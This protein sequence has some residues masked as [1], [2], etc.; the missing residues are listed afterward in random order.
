MR[1]RAAAGVV[2]CTV[3]VTVFVRACVVVFLFLLSSL[4]LSTIAASTIPS[5]A[6]RMK[7]SAGVSQFQRRG[8]SSGG[9]GGGRRA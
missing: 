6:S 3:V 1:S 5:A 8:S 9:S 4:R 7:T 2:D